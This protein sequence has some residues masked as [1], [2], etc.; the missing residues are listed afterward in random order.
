MLVNAAD[1]ATKA[2]DAATTTDPSTSQHLIGETDASDAVRRGFEWLQEI[3]GNWGLSD[4]WAEVAAVLMTAAVV[5]F[6]CWLANLLAKVF[7][8]S[9][10]H[11]ALRK[12]KSSWSKALI[13]Q[14]VLVRLS[15]LVP[16]LLLALALPAFSDYGV[17]PWLRP[18]IEIYAVG[19]LL[20]VVF[21]LLEV[22]EVIVSG[23]GMGDKIPAQGISQALKLL[24]TFVAIVLVLSVLFNQS[25]LWFLS[26]LGA[27]A[28]VMMLVFKDSILGLV[29]GIQIS[30][31]DMIRIGDWITIPAKGVDG[32]VEDITLTTIKIRAFDK[33]ISL[34]P[35][36]DLISNP[37]TNW[38]GMSESGGR[39][40]K[41]S[42]SIDLASIRFVGRADLERY[43]KFT[44][45][46]DELDKRIGAID[47]WNAKHRVDTTEQINGRQQTNIGIFRAYIEA[48]LHQHPK[49]HSEGFTFLI[50][51]LDPGPNGLPIELY[52][53]TNDNRWVPY[54][55]IQADIFD[56]LLAA[57]PEFDLAVFQSPSGRDVA[58][59]KQ[60]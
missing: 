47:D 50:R 6:V 30:T 1:I 18:L 43:R 36:Y 19:V 9:V 27:M 21:G 17:E 23:F 37:F 20:M 38:R 49:V 15:H 48:Y 14:R 12:S 54:E 35:S 8:R 60:G 24:F 25:P 26:G 34:V 52:V 53:F 32:D 59:L 22:G 58:S 51:H 29:A 2:T 13:E 3:A 45:L 11:R 57:V 7:I 31:N 56:H 41:R 33:T 4:L 10:A 44:V 39:R 46:C 42:I 5:V 40:I 16:V 55:Q 28:A